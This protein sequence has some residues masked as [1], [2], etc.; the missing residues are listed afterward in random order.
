MGSGMLKIGSLKIQTLFQGKVLPLVTQCFC[1]TTEGK[2]IHYPLCVLY[3]YSFQ[4]ER[5]SKQKSLYKEWGSF[6]YKCHCTF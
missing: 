1:Q 5:L 4:K 2:I 6:R 3:T